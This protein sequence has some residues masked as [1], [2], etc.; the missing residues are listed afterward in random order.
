M[1]LRG[2]Q[3]MISFDRSIC[4]NFEKAIDKEWLETNGMGGYASSTIIGVNTRGYHGLLIAATQPPLGRMVLLSKIEETIAIGN[5][6]YEI[7]CNQY[8]GAVHPKGYEHLDSFRLDPYPIF[9]YIVGSTVVEKSVFMV[10]GEN[11]TAITYRIIESQGIVTL[12]LRPLVACRDFHGRMHQS[13]DLYMSI[14]REAGSISMAPRGVRLFM[15]MRK[16]GSSGD[17]RESEYWYKDFEYSKEAYRGQEVY[18][19]LYS[20]GYFTCTLTKGEEAAIVASKDQPP[21]SVAEISHLRE[22]RNRDSILKVRSGIDHLNKL[23]RAADQFLVK[24]RDDFFSIIAGYHWFGDWGRDTM[25]ALPGLALISKRYDVA[26]AIL[27][28]FARHC[29]EGMIPNRFSETGGQPDYNTVDA[30]LW[31]VYAVKKYLDYTS[32]LSFIESELLLALTEIVQYYMIGTRYNIHM[33][34]DGLIYAGEEGT[35]LTWMDVKIGDLVVTPRRGK[36]VEINALW[37]NALKIMEE[38]SLNLGQKDCSTKYSSLAEK[39]K[40]SFNRTFWNDTEKCLYDYVDD[41]YCDA[42]V[43]PNQIFAI[44]LPYQPLTEANQKYVLDVVQEQLLTPFGL[45]S[46]SPKHEKYVGQYGGDQYSRDIAYHQGTV[47]PWLMGP[48]ITAYIKV[49]G[50]SEQTKKFAKAL[51]SRLL[52]KHLEDAGLGTISEIFDGD[53][54]HHPRGCIAQAWSVG[55]ILRAYIE[56]IGS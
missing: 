9:T 21:G 30:S 11:T 40:D 7:S 4:S 48:F 6:V 10:Y 15:S 13:N 27:R 36:A 20:P 5:E 55:E 32:D 34:K 46:L 37:Y 56:D 8:R 25:I 31:F 29:S 43:R 19:D 47:W 1:E 3:N 26:K 51:L 35:Q 24:R 2:E 54:P 41:Y 16:D 52:N 38:I 50:R 49:N 17:F 23:L 53:P 44:S 14:W 28:A 39:T 22:Q 45:R 12:R 18:E 33:D 42:S